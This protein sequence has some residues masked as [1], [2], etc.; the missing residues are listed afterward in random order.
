MTGG[1]AHIPIPDLSSLL[2]FEITEEERLKQGSLIVYNFTNILL[3]HN[4]PV[5]NLVHN[6]VQ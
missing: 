2:H 5:L 3:L 6:E 1:W 4:N